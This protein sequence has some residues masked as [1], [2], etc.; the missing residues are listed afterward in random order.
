MFFRR[1]GK[2]ASCNNVLWDCRESRL[3]AGDECFKRRAWDEAI[4]HY[5]AALT[6]DAENARALRPLCMKRLRS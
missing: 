1:N 2:L 6:L 5:T 3:R 4:S